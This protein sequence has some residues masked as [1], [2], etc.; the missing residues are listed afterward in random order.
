MYVSLGNDPQSVQSQAQAFSRFGEM[1]K[2]PALFH[3]VAVMAD[4]AG[5]ARPWV[6]L[7]PDVPNA[8]ADHANNVIGINPRLLDMHTPAEMNGIVGHELGHIMH[9]HEGIY[10]DGT[11]KP[12]TPLEKI[13]TKI[14]DVPSRLDRMIP[15]EGAE[16]VR[17]HHSKWISRRHEKQADK[18]GARL[19][20][21]S[22][23]LVKSLG[24]LQAEH[25]ALG[26]APVPPRSRFVERTRQRLQSTHP[27]HDLRVKALEKHGRKLA[28][29]GGAPDGLIERANI[30]GQ[31]LTGQSE[32]HTTRAQAPQGMKI[33]ETTLPKAG[34]AMKG[35][36]QKPAPGGPTAGA[37]KMSAGMQRSG[38][39]G[40]SLGR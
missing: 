3:D 22:K 39:R 5:L 35:L 19:A 21:H 40:P 14:L 32:G 24:K 17:E 36:F 28:K 4:K 25:E 1:A 33:A 11:I 18:E 10:P 8:N 9:K 27:R 15:G 26:G 20:G 30:A 13:T 34:P 12:T 38:V 29:R 23:G 2:H 6:L 16:G 31:S 37:P 7:S